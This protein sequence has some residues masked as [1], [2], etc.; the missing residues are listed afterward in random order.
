MY[1][2]ILSIYCLEGQIVSK[3]DMIDGEWMM[4]I[5]G[6]LRNKAY[7]SRFESYGSLQFFMSKAGT[8]LAKDSHL[9]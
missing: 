5:F 9:E 6:T 7:K 2:I 1:A 8:Q 4:N 3:F